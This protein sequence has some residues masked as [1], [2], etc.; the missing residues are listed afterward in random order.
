MDEGG[1]APAALCL[2][3]LAA[4]LGDPAGRLEYRPPLVAVRASSGVVSAALDVVSETPGHDPAVA[5]T[6]IA[7]VLGSGWWARAVLGTA[8]VAVDPMDAATLRWLWE[9]LLG[10]SREFVAMPPPLR[11]ARIDELAAAAG[12]EPGLVGRLVNWVDQVARV[13]AKEERSR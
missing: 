12:V 5:S 1:P 8:A 4:V 6:A 2:W 13:V 3:Y 10:R 11:F 7:V 9:R